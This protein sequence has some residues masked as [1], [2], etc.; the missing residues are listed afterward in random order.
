MSRHRTKIHTNGMDRSSL[1]LLPL[2]DALGDWVGEIAQR[3][4]YDARDSELVVH[5]GGPC[6]P[7]RA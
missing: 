2:I 7:R 1:K 5:N 6:P 3:V 4:D